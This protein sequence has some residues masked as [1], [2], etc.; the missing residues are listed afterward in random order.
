MDR[1]TR[2]VRVGGAPVEFTRSE[3]GLLA[4]FVENAG[5]ALTR[6]Q[7]CEHALGRGGS[8]LERTIDAH[9]RTIRRKLGDAGRCIIT[10]WGIGYRLVL[11]T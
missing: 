8:I 9:V 6:E 1:A 4:Y 11:K 10:V 2:E 3:F 7:L 5:R